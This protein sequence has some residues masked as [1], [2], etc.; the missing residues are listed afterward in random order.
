M[1][2]ILYLVNVLTP[3]TLHAQLKDERLAKALNIAKHVAM[4]YFPLV[5]GTLGNYCKN[6]INI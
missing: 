3:I 6:C 5:L 4:F 2:F 1:C